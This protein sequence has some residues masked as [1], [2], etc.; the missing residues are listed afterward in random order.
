MSPTPPSIEALEKQLRLVEKKLERSERH[1]VD[2]E[3]QHDRDQHLY[4]RLHGDL[5]TALNRLKGAQAQL[6]QQEKLASLGALTAGIAHEIKNPLNF[7]T[8]F[9]GLSRDLV[10]DL[11]AELSADPA[12]PAGEAVAASADLFDDLRANAERIAEHGARADAI[13]KGMLMHAR[14]GGGKRE[15]TAI[16]QLVDEAAGLAY[17][18][19][20]ATRPDAVTE[21]TRALDPAVGE[22]DVVPEDVSRVVLNLV[23]NALHATAARRSVV[24]GD[25]V[26]S[27]YAPSVRVETH[28][29]PGAVE[30]RVW[31][32]GGGIPESVR[33]RV[34]EPF[35]TTKPAGEGTGL[36]LSLAHDIA[37]AHGGTLTVAVEDGQ[38]TTFTLH[39]PRT[40]APPAA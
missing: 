18:G 31:D 26:P 25:G 20:R 1:R 3:N 16:N 33:A 19:L 28:A 2:L 4:R 11:R 27:A 38:T 8:N 30:I 32:N 22:A 37:R 39:L 14:S 29:T 40:P 5:E 12:R 21:V 15:P 17:H 34:F 10:D 36:G 24:G 7:V 23:S 6:V 35:F 9:A 13:V